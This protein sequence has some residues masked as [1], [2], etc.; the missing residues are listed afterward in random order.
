MSFYAGSKMMTFLGWYPEGR[1]ACHSNFSFNKKRQTLVSQS[2]RIETKGLFVCFVFSGKEWPKLR[3]S[4][5][6]TVAKGNEAYLFRVKISLLL[7]G[8]W[9]ARF[10]LFSP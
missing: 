9:I 3:G 1:L 6:K 8:C 4:Q 7:S 5:V 2:E 10:L